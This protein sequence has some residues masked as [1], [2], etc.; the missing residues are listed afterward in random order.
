MLRKERSGEHKE[1]LVPPLLT[2]NETLTHAEYVGKNG[3]PAEIRY[4]AKSEFASLYAHTQKEL[5]DGSH[6]FM[7]FPYQ[8]E[9][10]QQ[11]RDVWK[12]KFSWAKQVVFAGIGGAGIAPEI[13]HQALGQYDENAPDIYVTGMFTDPKDY[14]ALDQKLKRHGLEKTAFV[15]LSKSGTTAEPISSYLYFRDLFEK[16][17][18]SNWRKHF[19]IVAD[20]SH[21]LLPDEVRQEYLA[22]IPT[23][24]VGDR[25][26]F[27]SALGLVSAEAMGI[28]GKELLT[29]AQE[30]FDHAKHASQH[31]N[32]PWL[33][34]RSLYLLQRE[35]GLNTTVFTSYVPSLE[36]TVDWIRQILAESLGKKGKGIYPVGSLGP[37]DQHSQ[38]QYFN[39]GKMPFSHVFITRARPNNDILLVNRGSAGLN[40][41]GHHTMGEI[42]NTSSENTRLTLANFGRPSI[43]LELSDVTPKTL[44]ALI[45]T[46]QL[47]TLYLSKLYNVEP[48]LQPGVAQ[49]RTYIDATL[50][51]PGF[52]KELASLDSKKRSI[53]TETIVFG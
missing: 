12:D 33:I 38:L 36:R 25:W 43:H 29:G 52:E 51:R 48:Y 40:H 4:L 21:G 13:L 1:S 3:L 19:L 47:V 39:D 53:H 22:S 26:A 23:S 20:P 27:F 49:S 15:L 32:I 17:M 16:Q 28:D 50:N 34:A 35:N 2:Y 45:A 6:P 41:F 30:V 37:R 14:L 7:T 46:F 42:T 8:E 24:D 31:D 11:V 18:G 10:L 9:T 44:G 5:A